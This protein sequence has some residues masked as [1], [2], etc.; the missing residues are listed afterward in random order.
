MLLTILEMHKINII[1]IN[2]LRHID[3]KPK[4]VII[5]WVKHIIIVTIIGG[6]IILSI[7]WTMNE[8]MNECKSF[9]QFSINYA[10]VCIFVS[11]DSLWYEFYETQREILSQLTI[12]HWSII[13][14]ICVSIS[15][16]RAYIGWT[17]AFAAINLYWTQDVS[18]KNESALPLFFFPRLTEH[19]E[20]ETGTHIARSNSNFS[21]FL[22]FLSNQCADM[23][24]SW[25]IILRL[26]T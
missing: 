6:I 8:W 9:I 26:M 23:P 21:S 4:C 3:K 22:R 13:R 14:I 16:T 7:L 15:L 19:P 10:C 12:K 18:R 24:I 1:H 2:W 5:N 20:G 17:S 25:F 11:V